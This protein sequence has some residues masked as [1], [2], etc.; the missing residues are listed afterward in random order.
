MVGSQETPL[1]GRK[2]DFPSRSLNTQ[3][4]LVLESD[5]KPRTDIINA[6]LIHATCKLRPFDNSGRQTSVPTELETVLRGRV[7]D[8]Q[9]V[10][11]DLIDLGEVLDDSKRASKR[12]MELT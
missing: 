5:S 9:Y 6:A 3:I 10:P 2:I 8:S 1:P 11:P 12:S 4:Y 7:L